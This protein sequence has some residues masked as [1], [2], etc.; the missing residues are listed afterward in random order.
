MHHHVLT[1]PL[2]ALVLTV[3]VFAAAAWLNQRLR[4]HPLANPVLL[5]VCVVM[6]VLAGTDTPY[7]RYFEGAQFIHFLLGPAT[8]ALAVPMFRHLGR[9]R[10][11]LLPIMAGIVSGSAAGLVLVGILAWIFA[12]DPSLMASL[13]TRSVTAPVA[14]S[15]APYTGAIPSLAAIM[16]RGRG[17]DGR[18]LWSGAAR[19]PRRHGSDGA[20]LGHGRSQSWPGHCAH[21]ARKRGG[22]RDSWHRYGADCADHGQHD[23]TLGQGPAPC[24]KRRRTALRRESQDRYRR[25]AANTLDHRALNRR[26]GQCHLGELVRWQVSIW[27]RRQGRPLHDLPRFLPRVN[28]GQRHTSPATPHGNG[29]AKLAAR[30]LMAGDDSSETRLVIE[31]RSAGCPQARTVSSKYGIILRG[32]RC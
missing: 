16:A 20:R 17:H 27:S 24:L 30:I 22:R 6:L 5:S 8:V 3:A 32:W 1:Y 25:D 13:A 15:I 11:A 2:S 26:P 28:W 4:A 12:V 7:E 21:P 9:I 23:A 18:C 14:M 19:S 31:P 29:C 10:A